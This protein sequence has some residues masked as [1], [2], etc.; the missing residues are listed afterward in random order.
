MSEQESIP[1]RIGFALDMH[2]WNEDEIDC[3]IKSSDGKRTVHKHFMK[4]GVCGIRRHG[5]YAE[6]GAYHYF[7]YDQ[8][9]GHTSE[10]VPPCSTRPDPLIGIID[11]VLICHECGHPLDHPLWKHEN[12]GPRRVGRQDLF[13]RALKKEHVVRDSDYK[14]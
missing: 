11:E 4:C 7:G 12:C 8:P 1:G 10:F 5:A 6:H 9:G 3:P 2:K 13:C 14:P